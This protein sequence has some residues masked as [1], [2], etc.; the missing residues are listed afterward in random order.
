MK[1][2]IWL[3]AIVIFIGLLF[4]CILD[5][6]FVLVM[7]QEISL[8]NDIARLIIAL[9]FIGTYL[10]YDKLQMKSLAAKIGILCLNFLFLSICAFIE[11]L[12][13]ATHFH[14]MIGGSI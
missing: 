13:V 1:K 9:P 6:L 7:K 2:I 14:V 12:W 3:N 10:I 4:L 5:L 8:L 11:Y